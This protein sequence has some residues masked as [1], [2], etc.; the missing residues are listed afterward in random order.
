M[1]R[2][3]AAVQAQSYAAVAAG[4]D[5]PSILTGTDTAYGSLVSIKRDADGNIVSIE[6]DAMQINLLKSKINSDHL[7]SD[8]ARGH[9]CRARIIWFYVNSWGRAKMK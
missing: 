1:I 8:E 9:R 5:I 6:T 2:S 3:T 4:T 7:C